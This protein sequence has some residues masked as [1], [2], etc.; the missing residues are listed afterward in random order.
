MAVESIKY[1]PWNF[2]ALPAKTGLELEFFTTWEGG[3]DCS[4]HR[5]VQWIHKLEICVVKLQQ[6]IIFVN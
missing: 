3:G 4:A 5:Y 1:T 2:K 6:Q